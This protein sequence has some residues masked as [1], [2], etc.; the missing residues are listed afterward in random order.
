MWKQ[1]AIM[2]TKRQQHT[3][4]AQN[5]YEAVAIKSLKY[6]QQKASSIICDSY[7]MSY[8]SQLG[9]RNT[10]Q[11]KTILYTLT[12]FLYKLLKINNLNKNNRRI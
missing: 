1:K 9:L 10:T 8:Q 7:P 4:Y 12:S 5:L 6:T 2:E 3:Q 11:S